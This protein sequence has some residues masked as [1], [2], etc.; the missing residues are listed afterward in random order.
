MRNYRLNLNDDCGCGCGGN[1]N[2]SLQ[3]NG[4]WDAVENTVDN[5][6]C[7]AQCYLSFA[8]DSQRRLQCLANCNAAENPQQGQPGVISG[9]GFNTTNVLLVGG[10]LLIGYKLLS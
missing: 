6:S 3:L 2:D 7:T 5:L 8:S 1:C 9:G 10:A 4:I